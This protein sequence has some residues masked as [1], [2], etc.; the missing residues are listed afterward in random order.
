MMRIGTNRR[1]R[2][3]AMAAAVILLAGCAA[4]G[5]RDQEA[6]GTLLGAGV[7]AFLGKEIGGRGNSGAAGAALGALIGAGV[8]NEVGRQLDEADRIRHAR[9]TQHALETTRSGTETEWYN[10]DTGHRGVVEPRPAFQNP[11]G[12][13]CREFTQTI[14]VGGEQVE[15]YGTACR[16]PD[17]SWKIVETDN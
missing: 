2:V 17:G 7:G 14:T 11:E 6:V 3:A 8:G 5:S 15:G 10:P 4:D 1:G 16:Q 9:A 12:Q 13:Y